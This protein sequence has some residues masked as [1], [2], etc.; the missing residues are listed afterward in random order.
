MSNSILKITQNARK[1]LED[2]NELNIPKKLEE[3]SNLDKE[4]KFYQKLNLT[5][6]EILNGKKVLVIPNQFVN[7]LHVEPSSCSCSMNWR[8]DFHNKK[9]DS[10]ISYKLRN[11]E[12]PIEIVKQYIH[13]DIYGDIYDETDNLKICFDSFFNNVKKQDFVIIDEIE[14]KDYIDNNFS[15]YT[16]RSRYYDGFIE[17]Q[18][19]FLKP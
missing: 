4:L 7:V 9:C 3:I 13:F 19:L 11:S 16:K 18:V 10:C 1:K 17:L 2:L 15:N 6:T 8:K 14:M 12:Y 5:L